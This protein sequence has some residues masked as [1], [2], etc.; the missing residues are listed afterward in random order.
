MGRFKVYNTRKGLVD[1]L[2]VKSDHKDSARGPDL[3]LK[4]S[5]E[6]SL[7]RTI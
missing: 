5:R 1:R 3:R 7:G 2:K 4:H 6:G